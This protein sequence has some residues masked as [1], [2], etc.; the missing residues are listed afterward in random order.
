[1]S[2][3]WGFEAEAE[4]RADY[5]ACSVTNGAHQLIEDSW[6]AF[7]SREVEAVCCEACGQ[8]LEI[9]SDRRWVP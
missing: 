8:V 7:P 5:G 9:T 3:E 1:M 2:D 6:L 4:L